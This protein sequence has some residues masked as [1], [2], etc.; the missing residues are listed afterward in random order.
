MC[1]VVG[2]AGKSPVN[3]MLFDA[4]TMLQHRGQDAAGI[5]TCHDG[6]LFLRKDNGMVRD[7]FHTR[8]MR[9][10]K[11]N[12]GIGHVRYPTA[13]S[14][15]SAEAQ[16]F[17]V[18]SPYGI[19]LAHNGNLTNAKEIHDDLF[20]TDLRHMNTDSDSEVLLNVFAHELQKRGKLNPTADDIFH[21]VTRVHERCKGG[22]AVVAMI[23]DHGIVGFRDPNGIRPLI[24]GSRDTVDGKEYILASESVALTALGFKVERDVLPGEAILINNEGQLF[25]KQC[26]ENPEYRPCIFEYVYFARPDATIDGISVYKARL[27]MGEKLA[28]KISREWGEEHDIDVVIPIPDTSRTSALE[29]ANF[30]G[31]KFREGFMKNR[32]IGRTFI[33]P[34]QQQREKSVRQKLNPVELEFQ[35]KNVLLVDDSIVRG[36]TCNE[37]IQMARDSGAKKVF[38]ASAAPMVKYPNVYGIDMPVKSELIASERSVEEIREII[39]ADRLIFQDL[40]DLKDAVRTTKAPE[41]KDFD[42]SVFD[43][44]YV[45]GGIDE[46]YLDNLQKQRSESAKAKKDPYIDVNVDAASVDLTGLQ[47]G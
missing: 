37:I 7:V 40:E 47:E 4:L 31:V 42:C 25:T 21:V 11:G 32:Y 36:T 12:Y 2:I 46:Q 6:R 3:Q 35:N 34:G 9:A 18:N 19:T 1:G 14:S 16:P 43:G 44:V 24:L 41:V 5:V 13:G 8:H 10:L 30:L 22:Y 45:A 33:M 26:A 39:G 38:F 29:L 17:Y 15:S 28:Q 27:K 23:T 20:K